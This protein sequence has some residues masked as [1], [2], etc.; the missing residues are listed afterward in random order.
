MIHLHRLRRA[1]LAVVALLLVAATADAKTFAWKVTAKS[2]GV[3]YLVGS[4]HL[5]SSDLY[6]LEPPLESA[7][8]D[9]DLL[10]EEVDMAELTDPASQ[11][12]LLGKAML[13]SST[14]LDKVVSPETYAMLTKRAAAAGLPVEAFKVLKP[15]MVAL[16]LV[17]KEWQ[18]AGFDPQLGLDKHFYDQAKADGK[19]TQGLETAEYQISRLDD[20]PMEQQERLLA[21]SLKDLDAEKANMSR[22]VDS[23][24]SGD[25]AAVERIVL[26]ELKQEP[27]LYQRL[28]VERN[29]NWLPQIEALF[30]RPRHAMVVVGAAHLVGP[31][32]L[33]AMLKAKGYTVEQL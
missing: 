5:L 30:A 16:T 29:R 18:D 1:V 22:L 25:A 26:S 28:L 3:V 21:E 33:I 20:M 12:N 17:Q 6:P 9:S 13:P 10:V 11:M 27:A 23:W 14:P 31:D 2:G 8:K 4:V 24:R 19:K 7:Y 15:W 32:G